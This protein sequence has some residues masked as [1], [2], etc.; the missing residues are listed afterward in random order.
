[1]EVLSISSAHEFL[2]ASRAFRVAE[3][4]L[5]NVIG[6]VAQSVTEGRRY[7]ACHWWIAR[8]GAEVAGIAMRTLPHNLMISPMS[9]SAVAAV[10]QAVSSVFPDLP[11]MSGPLKHAPA[12]GAALRALN[13]EVAMSEVVYVLETFTPATADGE[14]RRITADDGA[15]LRT[16]LPAFAAEAG[17]PVHDLEASVARMLQVGW[18]WQ[19]QGQPVA[20]CGY[21]GPV[22]EPGS[23]VGRIGPVYTEPGRRSRGYGAAVTSAAIQDLQTRCE[24][25]MLYADAA[26]P[27][28][29]GVYQRLGFVEYARTGQVRFD[30]E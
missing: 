5:T 1:M 24:H 10:A 7:E 17:L 9:D 18:V 29:N 30:Y 13:I 27:A 2:E 8:E 28:S 14:A 22:G 19:A 4:Y 11:G 21:A 16:W 3:P 25:I 15:L 23:A 26:N 12:F 20:M 6:S